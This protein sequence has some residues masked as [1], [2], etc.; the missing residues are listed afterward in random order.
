MFDPYVLADNMDPIRPGIRLFRRCAHAANP[1]GTARNFLIALSNWDPA[2]FDIFY[3]MNQSTLSHFDELVISGKTG[4]I[5]PRKAAYQD[6]IK[7]Y[8]LNPKDCLVID[9]QAVNLKAAKELGFE[10]FLVRPG[11]YR[12]LQRILTKNGAIS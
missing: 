10:T 1:D 8:K 3:D 12:E 7:R 6:L 5:K 2:S 9:D 4:L 11:N